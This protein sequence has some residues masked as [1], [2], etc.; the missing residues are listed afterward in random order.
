MA[1]KDSEVLYVKTI[2]DELDFLKK[3][4]ITQWNI[5]KK[6]FVTACN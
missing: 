1:I 2:T 3:T 6:R 5:R 4:F